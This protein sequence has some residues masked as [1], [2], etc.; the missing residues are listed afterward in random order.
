[1]EREGMGREG[2]KKSRKRHGNQMYISLYVCV[3]SCILYSHCCGER[4]EGKTNTLP[5]VDIFGTFRHAC[6]LCNIYACAFACMI[7]PV[8]VYAFP[9]IAFSSFRSSGVRIRSQN[10]SSSS[11]QSSSLLHFAT[12]THTLHTHFGNTQRKAC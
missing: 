11:I 3:A 8:Y 9:Y 1:M 6:F 10:S 5:F 7:I 12:C 4:S 2:M